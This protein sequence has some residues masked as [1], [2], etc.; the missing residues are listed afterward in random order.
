MTTLTQ[1]SNTITCPGVRLGDY[2]E[3]SSSIDR[4]LVTVTA[5]VSAANTVTI[6]LFNGSSGTIN[7]AS[8]TWRVKVQPYL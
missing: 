2:V 3:V 8:S 6:L 5:Y 4:A 1:T 7:L